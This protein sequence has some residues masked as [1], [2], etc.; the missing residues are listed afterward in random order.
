MRRLWIAVLCVLFLAFVA[1]PALGEGRLGKRYIGFTIGQVVPGDEEIEEVDDSI[2]QLS[3]GI[4]LVASPNV[5]VPIT[6]QFVKM[7][8]EML[9]VDVEATGTHAG[10]GINYHF[11]PGNTVNPY[12]SV[13]VG[14]ASMEAEASLMGS[15]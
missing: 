2:L 10:I 1:Q 14:Y 5:D 12:I 7:E 13:E 6:F 8:G 3:A 9:G 15:S 4:N 11:S